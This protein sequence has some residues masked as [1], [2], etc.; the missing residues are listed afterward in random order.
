MGQDLRASRLSFD[1][2]EY[3]V[4]SRPLHAPLACLSAAERDVAARLA[5]GETL[6]SIGMARGVALRTVANQVQS[7]YRKLRVN[8]R[9]DLVS[10]LHR[11]P[12]LKSG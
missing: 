5:A 7:I 1:G 2:A 9:E 10:S 11:S 12:G 4:I 6:R 8:S 3:L